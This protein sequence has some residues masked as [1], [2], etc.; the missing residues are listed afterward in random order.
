MPQKVHVKVCIISNHYFKTENINIYESDFI[1]T[2]T[3]PS[4]SSSL[5][6]INISEAYNAKFNK[7]RS[8]GGRQY[9]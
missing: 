1:A 6:I 8:L 5:F 3:S 9:D 4:E 2:K 7:I